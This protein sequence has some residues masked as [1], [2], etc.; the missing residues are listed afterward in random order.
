M[1]SCCPLNCFTELEVSEDLT[2]PFK[3]KLAWKGPLSS[4]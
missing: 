3:C 2:S 1:F 4:R